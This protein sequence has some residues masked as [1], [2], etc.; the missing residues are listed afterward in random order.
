MRAKACRT[1]RVQT[2]L[3]VSNREPAFCAR[4]P[5]TGTCT[6]IPTKSKEPDLSK[7]K[8]ILVGMRAVLSIP[9]R[10]LS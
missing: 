6:V 7:S 4:E 8:G 10:R 2:G 5:I 9:R 1:A 3:A